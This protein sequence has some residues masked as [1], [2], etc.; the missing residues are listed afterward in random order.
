MVQRIDAQLLILAIV[1]QTHVRM[2]LPGIGEIG[3]VDLQDE[4]GVDDR[5]VF[6]AHRCGN[7]EEILFGGF[8]IFVLH[9]ML[10]GAGSDGREKSLCVLLAL[11]RRLQIGD[12][13][14]DFILADILERLDAIEHPGVMADGGPA[15][16]VE[17]LGELLHV[18]AEDRRR[19]EIHPGLALDE[20]AQPLFGIAGEIRFAQFAV[21]DHVDAAIDLLLHHFGHRLAGPLG[22]RHAVIRLTLIARH[23][24][25]HQI[26]GPRQTADM[27]D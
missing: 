10:H 7:G 20:S 8:V 21:I 9:P 3:I 27:R 22:Q 11:E 4:A 19:L 1:R 23:Q 6:F 16:A 18:A 15:A 2:H 17:I 25:L 13:G 5:L 14:V 26:F 24:H 12:V